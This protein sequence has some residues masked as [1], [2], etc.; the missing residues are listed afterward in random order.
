MMPLL[1]ILAHELRIL[2]AS[3]LVRLWLV[4]AALTTFITIAP[5]WDRMPSAPLIASLLFPYLVFPWFVVVFMLGISPVTGAR[6]ESLADG[7]LSRPVTRHEYLLACWT[8]RVIVVLGVYLVVTVPAAVI[9]AT[10]KRAGAA[11]PV[12]W[13]GVIASLAVV[14][15]VLMLLVS[16][17]FF[18]GSLLR[19]PLLAVVVLVFVWFPINAVLATF[20]LEQFSPISL[21][22]SL[23]TLLRTP[24]RASDENKQ[25]AVSAEDLRA[26]SRQANRFLSVLSGGTPQ[27]EPKSPKFFARNDYQDFSLPRVVLGYGIPTLVALLLTLILFTRRDL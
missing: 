6:L 11:D 22:Q 15:L 13:Y 3:W 24:W 26:L 19:K 9:V 8:A 5:N 14:G 23:P 1:A 20:S 16:L 12:T 4:A 2:W 7:V 27:A 10:A 21:N 18:A 25:E 17:A